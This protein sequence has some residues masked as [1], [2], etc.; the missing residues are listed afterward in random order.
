MKKQSNEVPA[1][2]WGE[3]STEEKDSLMKRKKKFHQNMKTTM[4]GVK[5]MKNTLTI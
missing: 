1:D 4:S 2:F 5:W 3:L